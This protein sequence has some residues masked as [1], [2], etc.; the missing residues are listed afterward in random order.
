M[1]ACVC[2]CE[3]ERGRNTSTDKSCAVYH[4]ALLSQQTS[5]NLKQTQT[6][7]LSVSQPIIHM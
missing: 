4:N 6:H 2:V 7:S 5:I 1:R 3:Y